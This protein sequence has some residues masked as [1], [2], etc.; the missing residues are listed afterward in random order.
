MIK[1]YGFNLKGFLKE[2]DEHI[3][4]LK[5]KKELGHEHPRSDK[6]V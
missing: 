3:K 2:K 5:K 6:N 1:K 4:R